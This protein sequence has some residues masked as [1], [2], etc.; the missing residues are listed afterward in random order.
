LKELYTPEEAELLVKMPYTL[1]TI[2]ASAAGIQFI[3]SGTLHMIL[4]PT[5]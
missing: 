1:S 3:A 2:A 5:R 4:A